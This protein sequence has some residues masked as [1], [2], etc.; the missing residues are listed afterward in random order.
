MFKKTNAGSVFRYRPARLPFLAVLILTG[1]AVVYAQ[2]SPTNSATGGRFT[3]DV[4]NFISTTDWAGVPVENWFS[5]LNI[6]NSFNGISNGAWEAGFAKKLSKLYIGLSYS[7]RFWNGE[8]GFGTITDNLDGTFSGPTVNITDPANVAFPIGGPN[9]IAANSNNVVSILLG[10]ENGSA[11]KIKFTEADG[12]NRREGDIIV[13]ETGAAD[14]IGFGRVLNGSFTP[15]VEWGTAKPLAFGKFSIKPKATLD[16]KVGFDEQE[17]Q[18]DGET[19][20]ASFR[21][22]SLTP[23]LAVDSGANTFWSSN[24]GSLGVGIA[25]KVSFRYQDTQDADGEWTAEVQDWKNVFTPYARF[26]QV[27]SDSFTVKAALDVPFSIQDGGKIGMYDAVVTDGGIPSAATPTAFPRIR[28]AV[29]YKFKGNKLALNA[30]VNVFLPA[31][32]YSDAQSTDSDGDGIADEVSGDYTFEWITRGA[33]QDLGLGASF[34]FTDN[35]MLDL[36]TNVNLAPGST[37]LLDNQ[38]T[39]TLLN[40]GGITFSLTF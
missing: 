19:V 23:T 26:T 8:S 39:R 35:A 1:A 18:V 29:Q 36:W 28:M 7:G 20:W 13:T 37:N 40:W 3:T 24:G 30:G 15:S 11:I 22:N 14:R 38:I 4:D 9:G 34:K 16:L 31:F 21:Q 17:V 25:D 5:Y 10:F 33:L 6:G 12:F 2:T 32:V 27:L